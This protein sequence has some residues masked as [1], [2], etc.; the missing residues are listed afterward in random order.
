MHFIQK[1]ER[2]N[3]YLNCCVQWKKTGFQN[4]IYVKLQ[5]VAV[6][7]F[8]F[9]FNFFSHA[10]CVFFLKLICC[11]RQKYGHL[12]MDLVALY[13]LALVQI[14]AGGIQVSLLVLRYW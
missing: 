11:K 14:T 3:I 1:L 8:F 2:E 6:V 13:L 7:F 5:L 9:C 12:Q 4:K 10:A